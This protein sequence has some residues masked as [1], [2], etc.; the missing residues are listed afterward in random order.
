VLTPDAEPIRALRGLVELRDLGLVQP[1]PMPLKSSLAYARAR[2]D[3]KPEG[4]A[5]KKA[6]WVWQSARFP[7]EDAEPAH[8]RVWGADAPLPGQE[9]AGADVMQPPETTRFGSLAARLW[10]PLLRNE[11]GSW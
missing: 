1:L 5:V 4:I 2:L 6:L 9:P 8:V 7:G 3:R 10:V 11:G